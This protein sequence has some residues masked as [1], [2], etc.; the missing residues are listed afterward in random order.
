M[1]AWKC[2]ENNQRRPFSH[3]NMDNDAT[4]ELQGFCLSI[5]ILY[6]WMKYL[7]CLLSWDVKHSEQFM[8]HKP[9]RFLFQLN[10]NQDNLIF[11]CLVHTTKMSLSLTEVTIV[12]P[13]GTVIM[14][15]LFYIPIFYCFAK[16]NIWGFIKG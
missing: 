2:F 12:I 7:H 9:V 5:L 6:S 1:S 3:A 13:L 10:L 8:K 11:I 14:I 4:S 16:I 15:F